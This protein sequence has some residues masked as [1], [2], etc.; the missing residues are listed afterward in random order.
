M[1]EI[2]LG[3]QNGARNKVACKTKQENK[4]A[5]KTVR[6]TKLA[7][8]TNA[9]A[10]LNEAAAVSDERNKGPVVIFFLTDGFELSEKY[11]FSFERDVR[12]LIRR[13]LPN[14]RINTIGFWPSQNDKK[15][16][17]RLAQMGRGNFTCVSSDNLR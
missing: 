10:A 4:A 3:T 15:L 17:Q 12:N 13:S 11:T 5:R 7:G 8:K 16:L 14:S 2:K 6:E 1:Q 9:M